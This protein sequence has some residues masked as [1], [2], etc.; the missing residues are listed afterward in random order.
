MSPGFKWFGSLSNLSFRRKSDAAKGSSSKDDETT[1]DDEDMRP[2]SPSYARSSEMYTHM[3]TM[4][5]SQKKK[6][7]SIKAKSQEQKS[8]KTK[9]KA[10]STALGRSQSMRSDYVNESPLLSAL[11]SNTLL[12]VQENNVG[13]KLTPEHQKTETKKGPDAVRGEQI[14][15]DPDN[16]PSKP[17]EDPDPPPDVLQEKPVIPRKCSLPVKLSV[18]L[19]QTSTSTSTEHQQ[20]KEEGERK[21]GPDAER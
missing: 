8:L 11:N 1:V 19:Q 2:R 17:A 12:S 9:S 13:D 21:T 3:G 16:A 4:P 7:K 10:K 20:K 14:H 18:D 5:R 15:K 6:D